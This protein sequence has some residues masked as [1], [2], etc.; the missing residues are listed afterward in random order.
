MTMI[1]S[2]YLAITALSFSLLLLGCSSEQATEAE[3][4]T[5]IRTMQQLA[6]GWK[7]HFGELGEEALAADYDDA[8]WETVPMPHNWNRVGFYNND[9]VDQINHKS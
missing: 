9:L 6:T 7:F 3:T 5:A 1:K 4:V 8:Q 2:F